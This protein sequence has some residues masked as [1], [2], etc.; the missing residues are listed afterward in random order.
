MIILKCVTI[1]DVSNSS[2][3]IPKFAMISKCNCGG[4]VV[5]GSAAGDGEVGGSGGD[6]L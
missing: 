5:P 1:C 2:R 6:D 3:F 4:V